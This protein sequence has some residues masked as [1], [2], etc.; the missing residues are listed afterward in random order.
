M[1]NNYLIF[2]TGRGRSYGYMLNCDAE[3][4]TSRCHLTLQAGFEVFVYEITPSPL[5]KFGF[6][7]TGAT[8]LKR[9]WHL[10]NAHDEFREEVKCVIDKLEAHSLEA[11]R[12][13]LGI[14]I[15]ELHAALEAINV[16]RAKQTTG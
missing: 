13:Y 15:S 2:A 12:E 1:A 14:M 4:V 10:Y 16:E 6:D 5:G 8:P 3:E 11:S 9:V 7:P